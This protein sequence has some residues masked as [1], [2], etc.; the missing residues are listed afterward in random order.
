MSSPY[1][2]N[3][4][5]QQYGQPPQFGA[6]VPQQGQP[7]QPVQPVAPQQPAQY[8]QQPQGAPAWGQPA[9]QPTAAYP[10][11]NANPYAAGNPYQQQPY[12]GGVPM[13]PVKQRGRGGLV[14]AAFLRS[15]IGRLVIFLVIA[16]GV[17]IY[18]FATSDNATRNSNGQ[19]TQSGSLAATDLAVGDCFDSPSGT[20]GISSV[21][22]IP[23]TQ[24]HDSQVY[25]E[26]KISEST[27]P[28]VSTLQ[29]EA[30]ADCDADSAT[31]AISADA[32]SSIGTEYF[33]PQDSDTFDS[34]DFFIC[35]LAADSAT[36]TTS[37][38]S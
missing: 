1:D 37:Y 14:A 36:L 19:V 21:K 9:T 26:P 22:A 31:S 29:T 6:P 16:G 20:S 35:A 18:H 15:A 5:Q 34:Q 7:Q 2:Q 38:V 32:P 24:A 25:A 17:A 27:F 28:G 23:C 33:F 10:D 11:P 30:K 13:Q 4:G 3:P 8:A 12:A